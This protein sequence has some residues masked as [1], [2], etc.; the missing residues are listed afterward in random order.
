[1]STSRME[2]LCSEADDIFAA[3]IAQNLDKS[4]HSSEKPQPSEKISTGQWGEGITETIQGFKDAA[5]REKSALP[6]D[7]EGA[8]SGSGSGSSGGGGV[9]SQRGGGGGGCTTNH[10]HCNQSRLKANRQIGQ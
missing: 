7:S 6:T 3:C 2:D 10:A 8:G 9:C 5:L 1:M 4:M